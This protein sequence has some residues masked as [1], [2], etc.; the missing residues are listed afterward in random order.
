MRGPENMVRHYQ[1]VMTICRAK[2]TPDLLITFTCNHNWIEIR[3]KL[4]EWQDNVLWIAPTCGNCLELNLK[5]LQS[6][7]TNKNILDTLVRYIA[8]S[9]TIS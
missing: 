9:N 1:T 3:N 8:L 6:D 4:Q 5:Q 2:G 7:L